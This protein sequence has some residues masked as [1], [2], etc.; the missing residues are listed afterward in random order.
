MQAAQKTSTIPFSRRDAILAAML[1]SSA[2]GGAASAVA[3]L[4][5]ADDPSRDAEL[6]EAWNA[7]IEGWREVD[8]S[9]DE[10][11]A[12][13]DEREPMYDRIQAAEKIIQTTS[14]HTP[15]G[16]AIKIKYLCHYLEPNEFHN[17][18]IHGEH[19]PQLDGPDSDVP[20]G[21]LFDLLNTLEKL[22]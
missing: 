10:D 11:E 22:S 21:Y 9:M 18:I 6:I 15:A 2:I 19:A 13:D 4:D 7:W 16:F 8:A 17:L 1:A 12:A 14:A 20:K 5:G 3:I